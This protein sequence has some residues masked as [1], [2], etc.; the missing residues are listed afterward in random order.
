VLLLTVI[1]W[2]SGCSGNAVAAS[3]IACPKSA[4]L[5]NRAVNTID[6]LVSQLALL[7][8]LGPS[9][10][11]QE[12]TPFDTFPKN[13]HLSFGNDRTVSGED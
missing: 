5:S 9:C 3:G 2:I 7:R 6:E 13:R 11:Y 12:P 4:V 1:T 10:Q 8:L